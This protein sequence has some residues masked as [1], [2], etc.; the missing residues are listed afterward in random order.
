MAE[1]EVRLAP[2]L[3]V[4]PVIEEVTLVMTSDEAHAL[5]GSIGAQKAG[6]PTSTVFDALNGALNGGKL[7]FERNHYSKHPA[8]LAARSEALATRGL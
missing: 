1:A 8:Y 6:G 2:P 3:P 4:Q 7:F 5:V